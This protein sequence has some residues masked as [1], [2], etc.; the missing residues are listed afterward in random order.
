MEDGKISHGERAK[1]Y[2]PAAALLLGAALLAAVFVSFAVASQDPRHPWGGLDTGLLEGVLAAAAA[3]V[4]IAL[5]VLLLRWWHHRGAAPAAWMGTAAILIGAF[6]LT[7]PTTGPGTTAAYASGGLWALVVIGTVVVLLHGLRSPA[8]DLTPG[9]YRTTAGAAA[10]LGIATVIANLAAGRPEPDAWLTIVLAAVWGSLGTAYL[11][12]GLVRRDSLPGWFG[13]GLVA[14]AFVELSHLVSAESE[15]VLVA[16]AGAVLMLGLLLALL[17]A[18]AEVQRQYSEQNERLRRSHATLARLQ[19]EARSELAAAEHRRHE[20]KSA[21]A[22]IDHATHLLGRHDPGA[23]TATLASLEATIRTEIGLLRNLLTIPKGEN[24]PF[25]VADALVG[26]VSVQ[27]LYGAEVTLHVSR[28]LYAWGNVHSTAEVVQGLLEN[29]RT[30]APGA[31]V[32]VRAFRA[33]DEVHIEVH[34]SGPG[35]PAELQGEIFTRG[36]SLDGRGLGLGLSIGSDLMG[37]QGG[38]LWLDSS[39]PGSTRFVLCLPVAEESGRSD[40]AAALHQLD[41][42]AEAGDRNGRDALAAVDRG[43]AARPRNV[44]ENDG[45][46]GR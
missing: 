14:L 33:G 31:P 24:A 22:A 15:F 32:E 28:S 6:V 26:A 12:V 2:S 20:A 13:L 43:P 39:R 4:S 3:A 37:A 30:H 5:A 40:S 34:D 38:R 17:G 19:A 18:A 23:S 7:E 9:P 8:L 21:L 36:A 27:Q 46:L 16:G 25:P 44:G 35:I 29:A 41:E 45:H 11:S 1:R 42:L 10:L